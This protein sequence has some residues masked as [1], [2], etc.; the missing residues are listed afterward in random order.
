MTRRPTE[1]EKAQ[2]EVLFAALRTY[3]GD[4]MALDGDGIDELRAS[5]LAGETTLAE[6]RENCPEGFTPPDPGSAHAAAGGDLCHDENDDGC[7]DT[8]GVALG[9]D[10]PEC[11]G[12]GYHRAGCFAAEDSPVSPWDQGGRGTWAERTAL[13]SVTGTRRGDWVARVEQDNDGTFSWWARWMAYRSGGLKLATLADAQKEADA[14]LRR[15]VG[16]LTDAVSQPA[17]PEHTR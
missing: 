11:D 1:A 13:T 10:C 14:W 5:F 12:N 15:T 3:D 16:V 6:I 7:C 9:R 2:A 4:D 17:S 8:C